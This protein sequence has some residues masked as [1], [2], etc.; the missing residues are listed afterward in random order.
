MSTPTSTARINSIERFASSVRAVEADADNAQPGVI[1]AIAERSPTVVALG[2]RTEAGGR[3][4]H[5]AGCR[6]QQMADHRSGHDPAQRASV[7]GAEDDQVGCFGS[8]KLGE[9]AAILAGGGDDQHLSVAH[10]RK[11]PTQ[12]ER[13]A[14]LLG[15]EIADEDPVVHAAPTSLGG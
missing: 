3:H 11:D 10:A 1:D 5:R 14:P 13:V 2:A 4:G 9:V 12:L 8:G 7:A 6:A 15:I